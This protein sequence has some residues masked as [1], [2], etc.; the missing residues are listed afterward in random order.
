MTKDL[1]PQFS[2]K[3]LLVS[4]IFLMVN[5]GI[6]GLRHMAEQPDALRS[7]APKLVSEMAENI[8]VKS[9]YD[10]EY[11]PAK[12]GQEIF[13]GTLIRTGEAEF[14]ELILDENIIRLD[15]QTEIRLEKNNFTNVSSYAPDTPRL[16]I[17]LLSGSI[18]VDAFDHIQIQS[19]RGIADLDHSIGI[20]TYSAPINR[21][22]V[23]T[24][25]A[26]LGLMDGD[27]NLLSEFTVPLHNQVTFVD[28]QITATYAALKPSKLKKELKMTPISEEILADEW[29]A[30]NAND[31]GETKKE[32][33]DSLI[34]S[35]LGYKIKSGYQTALSYLTFVP[36]ARRALAFEKAKTM[37]VYIL[38]GLQE[39]GDLDEAKIMITEFN[40]LIAQRKDDPELQSLVLETLFAIKYSRCGTPAY[41]LKEAL[42]A[43]VAEREGPH[44]YS[45]YLTDFRRALFEEDIQGAE[46][47]ADKW[48]D[49]W[50]AIL[51]EANFE[52]FEK[53]TQILNHT[54]LTHIDD[55]SPHVLGVFDEAGMMKIAFAEDTEEARFE[56]TT[57]RLQTAASLIA[58]YRYGIAKQ[59]LKNSYLDLDIEN[60]S[61]DLASTQIFLETG[62]LLA[63]RIEY[64]ENVLHGAAKPI[65]ETKFRDYFQ[66]VKRDEALSADLRKFFELDKGE[67]IIATEVTAPTAAQVAGQFLDA[68][69]NVNYADISLMPASGFYYKVVNARLMDRGTSKS[70]PSFDATYDFVTN[71]I[72]DVMVEGRAYQG[73]FTLADI[74]TF[75]KTG[76]ELESRIPT[77]KLEEGIELLITD[78]EKIEALEGQ[79]I[80]QDV[81]RQLAY[82]Q[83]SSYGIVIPE[84]K[85]GIEILDVLNLNSF[86]ITHALV[87]MDD[88]EEAIKISFD[89]HSGTGAVSNV[90]SEEG[91]TLIEQVEAEDLAK[92]VTSKILEV[93]EEL[94]VVGEFNSFAEKNDLQFDPGDLTYNKDGQLSLANLSLATLGL[95]V[96]GLYDPETGKFVSVSHELLSHKDIEVK[97]YFELLADQQIIAFMAKNDYAISEEHIDSTYPFSKIS[98]SKLEIDGSVFNFGLDIANTKALKVTG[99]GIENTIE[100]I[101]LQDLSDLITQISTSIPETTESPEDI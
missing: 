7:V 46:I 4:L 87:N 94:R 19:D 74:V 71:S 12:A 6:Y 8:E 25:A 47:V 79:A 76:G 86:H 80:A 77:P 52:E 55:I 67:I 45:V 30:R 57:D 61:S 60:L 2:R 69:I 49:S 38:G 26:N 90:V 24:G 10:E 84:V 88:R 50:N 5:L 27:G 21:L 96:S 44:V 22:M 3:V 33:S 92:E 70:T 62:K 72:T 31:F 13:S 100:E 28:S 59:C 58:A 99:T 91:V 1:T 89:Y 63:Q 16:E 35:S 95:K 53:Q 68:R 29:V 66:T 78:Q 40:E 65:D 36:E 14:A 81:A 9:D 48:L 32:F 41:L 64:A 101:S 17:E 18:W 85:S 11:G 98:I 34:T 75:L 15:E 82:N 37:L 83:L 23:V 56:V 97:E 42:M 39:S 51:T 20:V 43:Q 73:S 93:E 54:F